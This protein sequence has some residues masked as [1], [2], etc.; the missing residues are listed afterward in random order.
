MLNST[1]SNA[2]TIRSQLAGLSCFRCK[3]K[4]DA[5]THARICECSGPL[6]AD[7]RDEVPSPSG[8]GVWAWAPLLPV[9]NRDFRVTLG[10]GGTPLLDCPR[11][12]GALGIRRL[13]LKHEGWQPT[14]TFK[15]RGAAVSIGRALELGQSDIALATAGNSGLA[16]SAYAARAG[17]RAHVFVPTWTSRDTVEACRAWGADVRLVPGP[18]AVAAAE[19]SRAV[20][21]H[22][23]WSVGAWAE[24]YRVEGDKTLGLELLADPRAR[25]AD[26]VLWPCASGIGLVGTWKAARDLRALG[27][28][29]TLPPLVGVQAATCAPLLEAFEAG[30]TDCLAGRGWTDTAS[31]ARGLLAVR[32]TAADLVLHAVRDTGGWLCSVDDAAIVRAAALTTRLEGLVLAPE[33]AAAIAAVAQLR[34]VARLK[35]D[36]AAVVVATGAGRQ[37]D[38]FGWSFAEAVERAG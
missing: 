33:S 32:P 26:A 31:L 37:T 25:E 9:R 36:A 30:A 28:D 29:V 16:W 24:P 5:D 2:A 6:L 3:K 20:A 15:A 17:M 8:A 13:L 19:C 7:Y 10:E 38:Y 1:S 34:S 18:V 14:G 11:L 35:A 23:W 4:Y 12:A 21:E 27:R 22:G